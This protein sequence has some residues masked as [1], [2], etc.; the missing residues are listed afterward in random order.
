[1]RREASQQAIGSGPMMRQPHE[2]LSAT[3]PKTNPS[4]PMPI[5]MPDD[6]SAYWRPAARA[7]IL[8]LGEKGLWSGPISGR[9]GESVP[10]SGESVDSGVAEGPRQMRVAPLSVT[11]FPT[12]LVIWS[13]AGSF[14]LGWAVPR[15]R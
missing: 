8:G 11:K 4:C 14:W 9:M 2:R 12:R 1:M 10:T 15:T 13:G 7:G 6:R 3:L 5:S